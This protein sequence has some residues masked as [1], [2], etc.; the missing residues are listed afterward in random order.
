MYGVAL[1][2]CVFTLIAHAHAQQATTARVATTAPQPKQPALRSPDARLP[3]IAVVHRLN[4]WRLRAL[5]ARTDAPFTTPLDEQFTRTNI[6]AGYV[7]PDGRSVVAR[8][9]RADAE[10]LDLSAQ[11]TDNGLPA[12][13]TQPPTLSLVRADGTE[14]G[15]RFVG[16]DATTGLSLL[17]ALQPFAP[18]APSASAPASVPL[19]IGQQ[20]R[21]IAP[22]PAVAASVTQ[23]TAP[24]ESAPSGE[25]GVIFM[26]MSEAT[27]VLTDV[28]RSP[29]GKPFEVTVELERVSPEWAGGVAFGEAGALVGIVDESDARAARLVSAETV[30]AA[31]QRIAARRASVPQPWLGARGTSLATTRLDL[32]VTRGWPEQAARA[33][34]SRHQGVLLT[35]VAPGTPAALAGLKAGDVIARIS[36]RDVRGIEDM[37]LLIQELG[38]NTVAKFTVLRGE[39][40]PLDLPVRLSE[41]QNPA[42]ETAQAEVLGAQADV[43]L[44]QSEAKTSAAELPLLEA[45]ARTAQAELRAQESKARAADAMQREVETERLRAAGQRAQAAEQRVAAAH[46]HIEAA[47]VRETSARQRLAEA[48]ARVKAAG[49]A[50][51][52][53]PMQSLRLYGLEAIS[54]WPQTMPR[55]GVQTGLL[56]VSVR[57]DS[58]AAHAG[59]QSGDIIETVNGRQPNPGDTWGALW[60]D[61]KNGCTLGIL[62]DGQKLTLKMPPDKD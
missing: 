5:L 53:L 41:A 14:I 39:G 15:A 32:L 21:V 23:T 24:T 42:L 2:V 56:V 62:R 33:L 52:W 45:A 51:F 44:A 3:V 13:A 48:E 6:V 47:R 4:G 10:M 50:R 31:A 16:L 18:V 37:S 58:A 57:K 61:S 25:T 26:N 54:L 40:P 7:L 9:P 36:Q 34:M 8:L 19:A 55:P 49:V 22:V 38:S 28:K 59:V 11:L 17:E 20:V 29:T 60:E 30:R 35:D 1:S 46:T 12:A 43:Q 27:G